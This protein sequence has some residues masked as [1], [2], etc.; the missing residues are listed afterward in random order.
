VVKKNAI[1]CTAVLTLVALFSVQ[2]VWAE[3]Q[4]EKAPLFGFITNG[5]NDFWI[6]S[7]RGVEQAQKDLGIRTDFRTPPN[8]TMAEQKSIMEDLMAKGASGIAITVIDPAG[9]TPF[10]NETAKKIL[11][12]THDSDAAKSDRI[13]YIGTNNYLAGHTMGKLIREVLPNGGKMI[14]LVGKM[15]VQ[16][17]VERRQGAI[18]ELNGSTAKELGTVSPQG[19]VEIAN[20]KWVLLDTRVDNVDYSRA[21]QNA[22]DA[23]IS[24]PD[25]DLLVGLWAYNGP[26]AASALKDAGLIGKKKVLAFDNM[27]ETLQD[28]VDGTIYATVVQDPYNFGYK[29][30]Q[31]LA[32]LKKGDKSMVPADGIISI[33]ERV[34]NKD[35]VK[36]FW[37]DMNKK[38]GK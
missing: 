32:A 12:T 29:S 15:D 5:V 11:V 35:N 2:A 1:L 6:L 24:F 28:I 20:G 22:E 7:Q 21:K 14:F 37:D 18:D 9:M 25:L 3:G 10:L 8:G 36:A 27:D 34:I 30:M 19:K 4:K 38:L 26:M 16:N 23:I 13:A 33:P 17:A 31:L